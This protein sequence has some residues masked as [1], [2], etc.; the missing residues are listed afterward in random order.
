M[1]R[2]SGR[3]SGPT[4]KR[5][6]APS[7]PQP[8]LYHSMRHNGNEGSRSV[9]LRYTAEKNKRKNFITVCGKPSFFLL[10]SVTF[11]EIHG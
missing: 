11:P 1:K 10:H 3:R 5:T 9:T 2:P 4:E 8:F 7:V 6:A